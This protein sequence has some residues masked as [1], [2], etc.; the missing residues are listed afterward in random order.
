MYLSTMGRVLWVESMLSLLLVW[1]DLT[2]LHS[3]LSQL[4][5]HPHPDSTDVLVQVDPTNFLSKKL[6]LPLCQLC[7]SQSSNMAICNSLLIVAV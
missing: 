2:C 6:V 5:N 4:K 1:I 7:A 3:M